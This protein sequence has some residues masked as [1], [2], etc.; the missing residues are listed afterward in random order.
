MKPEPAEALQMD[1][2]GK[3]AQIDPVK[4]LDKMQN[5]AQQ[6]LFENRLSKTKT[7]TNDPHIQSGSLS[8][9]TLTIWYL[10]RIVNMK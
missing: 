5:I 7:L 2:I 3:N 1:A 9:E 8:Y 4:T 6:R 10:Y